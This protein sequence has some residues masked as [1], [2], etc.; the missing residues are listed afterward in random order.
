MGVYTKLSGHV[1][2]G[3]VRA[4]RGVS[5]RVCVCRHQWVCAWQC[6]HAWLC[7]LVRGC[8][9]GKEEAPA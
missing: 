1:E 7:A 5:T 9:E 3:C 6:L 4:C 2:S 8:V